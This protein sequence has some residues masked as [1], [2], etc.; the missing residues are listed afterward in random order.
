MVASRSA[1]L[2][3]LS[4]A[5]CALPS[6]ATAQQPPKAPA[7]AEQP[8]KQEYAKWWEKSSLAYS[9]LPTH[10]L[11]HLE[12][13][14]SFM[15]LKGNADG[16][17]FNGS[18]GFDIRKSRLTNRSSAEFNKQQVDYTGA[19]G[20]VRS[21]ENTLRNHTEFDLTK[22]MLLVGGIE[23]YKN[24][25]RF[26][27]DRVTVYGGMG[28]TLAETKNHSVSING[29]LGYVRFDFDQVGIA[30]V[31]AA[32]LNTLPTLN[33]TSG[34]ALVNQMWR[35]SIHRGIS[36]TQTGEAMDYFNAD[37]GHRWSF[38]LDLNLPLVASNWASVAIGYQIK[39]EENI[40]T[41]ALGVKAQDRSFR[42]GL[43]VS[44]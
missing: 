23:H 4:A 8:P 2:L 16:T 20:N 40:Y 31:N 3:T 35:W 15:D 30:Q 42:V 44:R 39:H 34:G 5:L 9:P 6:V 41:D 27:D 25:V 14:L 17:M 33:P 32:A 7:A 24:T 12:A 43:R 29:G 38:G 26:I 1:L 36:L 18:A 22:K 28:V 21:T 13:T 19:G 11:T 37:L 10:T